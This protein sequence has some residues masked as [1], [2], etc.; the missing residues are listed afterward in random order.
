MDGN[1]KIAAAFSPE[2]TPQFAAVVA[3]EGIFIRDHWDQLTRMPWWYH[4][5]PDLEHAIVWRQDVLSRYDLDWMHLP[6][7]RSRTYRAQHTIVTR[8]E[9]V[10]LRNHTTGIEQVVER[11]QIG[12]W[13]DFGPGTDGHAGSSP[14]TV[15]ELYA[16]LPP[17]P[18][19]KPKVYIAAGHADLAGRVLETFPGRYPIEHVIAPLWSG[20]SLWGF[21]GWMEN[22]VRRPELVRA[23]CERTLEYAVNEVRRASAVGVRG[24]WIEDCMTDLIHPRDYRSLNLPYLQALVEEIRGQGMHSI[25]YFCG[26]PAGKL[27]LLLASEA[28]ALA[29]EESKKGFHIDIAEVAETVDGRCALLGNLD[30]IHL[31]PHASETALRVEIA[32]QLAAGKRNRGRFVMSTGSPVT[33]GTSIERLRLYC[34]LVHELG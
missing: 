29:L 26:S 19:F 12:G 17:G 8:G 23:A 34:D 30:A 16:C 4:R 18:D 5:S 27:D 2:G 20:Y 9:K 11:P 21:E 22:I 6:A 1:Q 33:P 25:H 14:Q 13:E 24:I 3:Y 10:F 31:L 28:D 7:G 32:R 15:E